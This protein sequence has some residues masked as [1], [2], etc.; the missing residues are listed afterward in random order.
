MMFSVEVAETA[1]C[2]P[3]SQSP[4]GFWLRPGGSQPGLFMQVRYRKLAVFWRLA[5]RIGL[6]RSQPLKPQ[7]NAYI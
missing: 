3:C 6:C 4:G 5:T 7:V 2:L 1:E